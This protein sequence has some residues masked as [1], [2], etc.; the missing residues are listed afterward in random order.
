METVFTTGKVT[1]DSRK[2]RNFWRSNQFLLDTVLCGQ[3]PLWWKTFDVIHHIDELLLHPRVNSNTYYHLFYT[4]TCRLFF[5]LNYFLKINSQVYISAEERVW[6]VDHIGSTNLLPFPWLLTKGHIC[7][8]GSQKDILMCVRD[9]L[10]V[11][12]PCPEQQQRDAYPSCMAH[13]LFLK[14]E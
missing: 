7:A 2:K 13:V 11:P 12:S 8:S 6:Y 1:K 14:K 10:C 9:V 5:P 4:W 3:G